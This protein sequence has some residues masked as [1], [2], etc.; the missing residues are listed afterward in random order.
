[1]LHS[2]TLDDLDIKILKKLISDA[3]LSYRAIADQ[4][5]V[6]PPTILSRVEKLE[7]NAIIK[8]YSAI[9]DHEKIRL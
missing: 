9:L 4:I 3:R 2:N 1:M 8:S 6:S 5:G 7:N